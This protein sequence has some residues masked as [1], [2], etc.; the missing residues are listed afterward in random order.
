MK[1]IVDNNEVKV[2]EFL[3]SKIECD[4]EIA[5]VSAYFTI[6]AFDCLREPLTSAKRIRFL[7]GDPK[8]VGILDPSDD[9]VKAFALNEHEHLELREVLKQKP[10]ALECIKWI[11]EKVEI[12]S[13]T[14]SGFLHGKLY[15]INN[16]FDNCIAALVGSSNFTMRGLGFGKL[17][18]IELNLQVRKNSEIKELNTWF[19]RLWNDKKMTED[20][21][22]TV[23]SA[24]RRLSIAYAPEFLYYKT[25]FHIF[26][27]WIDRIERSDEL[28]GI[29]L[30]ETAI[31]KKLFTFQQQGVKAAINRLLD[32]N[33]CII[34]DSV[35][36][37]KTFTALAVIRYF[38]L[39][40]ERVLVLCPK[41]LEQNWIRYTSWAGYANNIF[42]T[43]RFG[44]TVLAHTD[45][46]RY[47]GQSGKVDL[48]EF[49][50]GNFDLVV[51][52]ESHN[53]RNEGSDKYDNYGKLVRHSRYNRLLEEVVKTGSKTKVLMLSATPV[54]T[55]LRD[56][57]NQI[58]L[59]VEKKKDALREKLKIN[60]IELAFS[61]A[62]RAFLDWERKRNKGSNPS[63]LEL[64]QNLGT[65]F[66]QILDN[67]TIARSREH[68]SKYYASETINKIGGFPKRRQPQNYYPQTDS[69]NELTYEDV[70][71]KIGNLRLAVYLPSQYVKDQTGFE[72]EREQTNF[73]QRQREKSLV[74]M[75]RINL[76]KR[77]ESSINAFTLTLKRIKDRMNEVDAKIEKW[78][79]SDIQGIEV[80]GP[81][82]N[83]EDDEFFIGQAR[84]YNFEEL[85]VAVWQRDLREDI[86]AIEDLYAIAIRVEP[87]RDAKLAQLRDLIRNKVETPTKDT[88]NKDNRKLLIFTAFSDTA[89]YLYGQ[90]EQFVTH[91]LGVEIA[92][93]T[94]Q[95][96]A[97]SLG[98]SNYAK[99]L[100]L[101][102]P[103]A[104]EV[105]EDPE[106][107][108]DILI[109]TD[110]ISEGQNLQDCD[111]VVNY[112]I[113]WNPVRIMQRFGRID[114]LSTK[115]AEVQMWNF[116]PTDNFDQ[117]L[118]LKNRVEARMALVDVSATGS[119][120]LL[121]NEEPNRENDKTLIQNELK[122]RDHQLKRL[123]EEIIDLDEASEGVN[124]SEMT[125]DDFVT[126]L[127]QYFKQ[128]REELKNAPLGIYALID[129]LDCNGKK[130]TPG[131]IF[132]FKVSG[133]EVEKTPN[134]LWPFFLI[135]I[136]WDGYIEYSF[137][138]SRQCLSLLRNLAL[139]KDTAKKEL[140]DAFDSE[141]RSGQ[142]MHKYSDLL[143][144]AIKHIKTSFS[145]AEAKELIANP[146]F[147]I[148]R[149]DGNVSDELG[150]TLVTWILLHGKYSAQN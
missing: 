103:S 124:L 147:K 137:K 33:G 76:E 71:N 77:L 94:G 37:G 146:N 45:L 48:A 49:E 1:A 105:A 116:W 22:E 38:E 25:L 104:Q 23:I 8:S 57:R 118:N 114:R 19:N 20:V 97:S 95:D 130:M 129:E 40:N 83:E 148:T 109:A 139:G 98:E 6:Y 10:L 73:D 52:D 127:H 78:T 4:S 32:F 51:I 113:H 14:K 44:Y 145:M 59:I 26:E 121:S 126:D 63:K 58:Y 62:Q 67:F 29:D 74:G 30:Y 18:N 87:E 54:N 115:N 47:E 91:S 46:S 141:T 92:R 82:F 21:K 9:S 93:I 119:D 7:Y 143:D 79:Y 64:F 39:R 107:Q 96:N 3:R 28:I 133:G 149:K 134:R 80:S 131:I 110:C 140:E 101:F 99:I 66:F 68:I 123:R 72:R 89:R 65:D 31:W 36:L 12:R 70:H 2:G 117:Y 35:G 120:D 15:C 27:K 69:E 106:R 55:N 17:P 128:H 132:C 125:L 90:L 81:E 102:A 24:L 61:V 42:V 88:D 53:F 111:T 16:S 144:S 108:I 41:K 85:N 43:D 34:A 86:K 84:R 150:F 5:I 56:L 50:W 13:V 138:D 135:Y 100:S 136:H 75:L 60:S 112:D 142:D 11:E 122:F